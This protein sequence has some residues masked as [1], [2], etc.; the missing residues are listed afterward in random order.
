M[1]DRILRQNVV[2]ELDFEPGIRDVKSFAEQFI[3]AVEDAKR[4]FDSR[5]IPPGV[6]TPTKSMSIR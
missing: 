2:D 5:R 6:S 3:A 4:R 1:N